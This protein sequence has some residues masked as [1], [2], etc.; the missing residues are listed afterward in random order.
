MTPS[1]EEL[2]RANFATMPAEMSRMAMA[3]ALISGVAN[4]SGADHFDV[5]AAYLNLPVNLCALLDSREGVAVIAQ[6][7]AAAM[8]ASCAYEPTSH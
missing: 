7:L 4:K 2:F 1:V 6:G 5:F 8:G 3:D